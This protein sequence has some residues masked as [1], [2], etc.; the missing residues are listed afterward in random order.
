M[1]QKTR[2]LFDDAKN[3]T[4]LIRALTVCCGILLALDFILPRHA[5]HPLEHIPGF[6]ALYGFIG[7]VLLVIIAKWLR[8][9]LMRPEHYYQANKRHKQ[10]TSDDIDA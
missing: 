2:Y 9:W 10:T 3:V 7:C 6:Y 1:K 4:R 5:S 8:Y